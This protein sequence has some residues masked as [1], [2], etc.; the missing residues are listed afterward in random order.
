MEQPHVYNTQGYSQSLRIPRTTWSAPRS[1]G[2]FGISHVRTPSSGTLANGGE[3]TPSPTA[4]SFISDARS[5]R[6]F[7]DNASDTRSLNPGDVRVDIMVKFLRQRQL[8]KMWSYNG[9][10]EEGVILKRGKDDFACQPRDLLG[11]RDGFY[12]QITRLNVKVHRAS[13][14]FERSSLTQSSRL[15]LPYAQM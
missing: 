6:S 14:S 1:L 7:N 13:A 8:E 15:P 2:G 5:V 9:Q 11:V 10:A 4:V 3:T 12:D